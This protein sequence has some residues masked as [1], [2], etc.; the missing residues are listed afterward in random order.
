[1][2][3]RKIAFACCL[4]VGLLTASFSALHGSEVVSPN[5]AYSGTTEGNE[6][7]EVV[8]Y[9][10]VKWKTA[11]APNVEEGKKMATTL[12]KLKCEVRTSNHGNHI[13]VTYRCAAWKK[14]SLK[15]HP[16]AH[17]W[18]SWLKKYGFETKH[19]H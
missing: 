1:M 7:K 16:T 2:R 13:D 12:K 19:V 15:D 11:H 9:R 3:S 18:E 8:E 6:S 17:K 5:N 10:L 4:F 14:L